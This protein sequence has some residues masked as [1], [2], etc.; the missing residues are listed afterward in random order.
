VTALVVAGLVQGGMHALAALGVVL[1]HR[2]TGTLSFAQGAV[3]LAA[4]YTFQ[5]LWVGSGVPLAAALAAALA[6]AV[7]LG[8]ALERLVRLVPRPRA[9][10]RSL[11]T[12]GF[13][14]M[15]VS[16]CTVAFGPDPRFVPPFFPAG[17]VELGGVRVTVG[18]LAVLGIAAVLAV[19]GAVLLVATGTG[20]ALRA[21]SQ[22]PVAA[23]LMGLPVD[24][25]ERLA[26][27]AGSLLS[28][29]AG[30]LLAPLVFL[31]PVHTSLFFFLRPLAAGVAAGLASLPLVVVAALALGAGEGVLAPYSAIAGLPEVLTF[32]VVAASLVVRHAHARGH[33]SEPPHSAAEPLGDRVWRRGRAWPGWAGLG[34]VAVTVAHLGEYQATILELAAIGALAALSLVVVTGWAG[35]ISLAQAALFGVGAF[36]AAGLA[37]R[38]G[39]PLPAVLVLA[40]LGTVPFG[41][42]LGLLATRVRGFLLAVATFAFGAA[43][44]SA[45]FAWPP[46]TGGGDG[47]VVPPPVLWGIDLTQGR[48]FTYLVLAVATGAFVACRNLARSRLGGAFAAVRESEDGAAALGIS[49]AAVKVIAF[50][51]SGMLAGLAG[52]LSAYQLQGVYAT[53]YHP[54]VSVQML[55]LAT[56]GG[57][58]SPL[59]AVLAGLFGAALPEVLRALSVEDATPLVSST[60]LVV[61]LIALPRGLASVRATVWRRRVAAPERPAT[62]SG[63]PEAAR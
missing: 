10:G 16:T 13:A 3:A 60:A 45:L 58:A 18:E 19:T 31:D 55:A 4:A 7:G 8:L 48:G 43:C 46:F 28:G 50:S 15:V 33:R 39:L 21:V 52:C 1:I 9:L 5:A 53:Q 44:F 35:Q 24:R 23:R 20:M 41:V 26:W 42:A 12:L 51:V 37:T 38:A 6:V 29:V 59:G 17:A 30:V 25:L 14:G 2:T 49:P 56:V 32:A 22:E 36:T 54:L 27:V 40:P 61:A 11:V 63:A 34:L 62:W 47:A 57:I